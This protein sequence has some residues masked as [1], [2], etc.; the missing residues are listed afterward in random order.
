LFT[1]LTLKTATGDCAMIKPA[2]LSEQIEAYRR[3]GVS[4]AKFQ[5]WF[6]DVSTGAA[7]DDP[8]TRAICATVDA[9]F[10]AYHFD[11]IGEDAMKAELAGAIRPFVLDSAHSCMSFKSRVL[12]ADVEVKGKR[13]LGFGESDEFRVEFGAR[14]L[15]EL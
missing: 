1:S 9:A 12:D 3:G 13:P 2:D 6:E 15:V 11:H 10:S 14:S 8:D 7:Y 5:E 4:L